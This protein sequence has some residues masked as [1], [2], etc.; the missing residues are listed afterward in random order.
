MKK[1][2]II[3]IYAGFDEGWGGEQRILALA[4]G[5]NRD[6]FDFRI[7]VIEN[8]NGG[9]GPEVRRLGHPLYELNRSRRFKHPSNVIR[10]ILDLCRLFKKEKPHIVHTQSIN[11]NVLGRIAARLTGI[12]IIVSTDN[13]PLHYE[14]R[15]FIRILN[16]IIITFLDNI[17]NTIVVTSE[18]I[19]QVK[20][21]WHTLD[22]IKV[23]NT[24]VNIDSLFATQNLPIKDLFSYNTNPVIGVVGRLWDEKGQKYLIKSMPTILSCFPT[25]RL[26]IVGNGP[27]EREL[28]TLVKS[29]KLDGYIEFTGYISHSH[30]F[31]EWSRMDIAVVPSLHDARP[32]VT[33]EAMA[34][35]LPVV[36]TCVGGISEVVVHGETGILVPPK[37]PE[38]LAEAILYLLANPKQA[39]EM[40]R[41]GRERAF[42]DFHPSR[43]IEA[44]ENIYEDL[45][46]PHF[47][48]FGSHAK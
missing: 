2:K 37:D 5:L 22:K 9:L 20:A 28:K 47:S 23:I 38:A 44:H 29:L 10:V 15:K 30:I 19:S 40:G 18:E 14:A 43:F 45:V 13:A 1:I 24:P 42:Q 3:Y 7:C 39:I 36:G 35:G 46:H 8:A 34:L 41:R 17:S 21:R 48:E 4:K 16:Q 6:R 33:L 31:A 25:A 32:I 12:P 27:L 26:L 11:S